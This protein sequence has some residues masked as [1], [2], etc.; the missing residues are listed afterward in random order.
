MI[1]HNQIRN[2]KRVSVL[3]ALTCLMLWA[4]SQQRNTPVAPANPTILL[5]RAEAAYAEKDYTA[6]AALCD[7]ALSHLND[8]AQRTEW[9]DGLWLHTMLRAPRDSASKSLLYL[10]G[11]LQKQ[12]IDDCITAKI[13]GLAGFASLYTRD[14]EQAV[15]YYERNLAGLRRHGCK[16]GVGTAYMNLGFVLK[17]QGDFRAAR[18]P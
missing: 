2:I 8:V 10:S 15:W 6:S 14:F 7:T 11:V 4:W 3:L 17:E 9:Y 12:T 5:K 13:Y 1:K 16:N 18:Q